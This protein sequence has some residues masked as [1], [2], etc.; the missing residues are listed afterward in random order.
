MKNY[1]DILGISEKAS[2]Q[3]I[4]SSF[5]KLAFKYHPDTNPGNESQAATRFKEINEAY[6]VL[7]DHNKRQQYDYALKQ[8]FT[9]NSYGGFRYSQQDIFQ[10]IFSNQ[11]FIDELGYMFS[12][13][14]LRFDRDFINQIFSGGGKTVYFYAK[15]KT[16]GTIYQ[17][18]S[19]NVTT[20]K[21]SW[22]ESLM[23]RVITR[24]TRFILKI[25]LGI[26]YSSNLDLNIN[27]EVS[28][29]EVAACS[30]KEVVYKR[31]KREK[32]LIVTIPSS[33]RTGTIIRLKRMGLIESNKAGDLYLHITVKQKTPF[34]L[35]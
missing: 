30:E 33:A 13:V 16:T 19:P 25:L 7:S 9:G 23:L 12:Q 34:H 31:G 4:R 6:A 27:L 1:Y 2:Q 28:P 20:R 17:N 26:E 11:V 21:H 22:L 18:Y 35:S 10:S 8:P 5:R 32:K 15:P 24:V 3:T 14:G 29:E